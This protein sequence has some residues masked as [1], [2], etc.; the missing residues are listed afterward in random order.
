MMAAQLHKLVT[1]SSGSLGISAV[2]ALLFALWSA[3]RGM[4]GMITALDI[5][6]QQKETRGF[7]KLNLVAIGLTILALI[8]GTVSIALVGVLP[9]AIQMSGLGRMLNGC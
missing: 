3:S 9:A 6:Y 8:G 7:F 1:A 4:S 2:V 5:A